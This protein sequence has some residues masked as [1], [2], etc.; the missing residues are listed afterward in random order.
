MS[1]ALRVSRTMACQGLASLG[2]AACALA[3]ALTL[4]SLS[5]RGCRASLKHRRRLSREQRDTGYDDGLPPRA[6]PHSEGDLRMAQP[7]LSGTECCP[8]EEHQHRVG[9]VAWAEW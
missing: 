9:A 4:P 7:A 3:A 6:G 2:D 5:L 1:F 8:G